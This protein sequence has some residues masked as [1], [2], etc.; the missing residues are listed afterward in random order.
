MRA[1]PSA[2]PLAAAPVRGR[3]IVILC[4]AVL[5]AALDGYDALSMAFVAPALGAAWHLEKGTLGLLLS[6]GLVGMALGAIVVTPLADRIGRRPVVLGCLSVMTLGALLSGLTPSV[7]LLA[8]ARILTGIGIGTMVAMTT[9]L[10]S[11]FANARRS[12]LAVAVVATIGFPIGG[13]VGGLAAAAILRASGWP[14][15]FFVGAMAGAALLALFAVILP[16]SPAFLVARQPADALV[17]LNRILH[18]LGHPS[19]AALPPVAG[20]RRVAYRD[21]FSPGIASVTWRLIAVNVLVATASY[22]VLQWLPLLVADAGFP[23]ATGSLVSA[24][25]GVV[26]LGSGVLMGALAAR[27]APARLAAFAMAGI[28]LSLVAIGLAPPVLPAFIMAAGAF[29]LFLAGTTGVFYAM[30]AQ[31]FPPLSRASG[32]GLVMGIGRVASALGPAL[33]GWMFAAGVHRAGVS[34]T[35]AVGPAIAAAIVLSLAPRR[36]D[37]A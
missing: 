15:V 22:Y 27:I 4:A 7:G 3:Q 18:R 10:S 9:L 26:G 19:L 23:P 29:G 25:S 5:L 2:N 1:E 20:T 12:A 33:A 13:V 34:L 8:G 21:L 35:F 14:W 6:S 30:L 11:E 37:R 24:I 16:E 28:A 32:I 31:S 36:F 17:R